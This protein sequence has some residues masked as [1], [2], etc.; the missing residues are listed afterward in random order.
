MKQEATKKRF[1]LFWVLYGLFVIAMIIFW[2]RAVSYV[3]Q[4]LIRYE[5]SQ[6][7]HS[8]DGV[9][10]EL[11]KQ[12]LESYVTI[13]GEMSRFETQE[14]FSR[15]AQKIVA[16]KILDYRTSRGVQDPS[17]PKYDLLADGEVVGSVTLK[18]TS[19]ETLFLNLLKISEWSL[20]KVEMKSVKGNH[21]V[22]I[23]ALDNCQVKING[24]LVDDRERLEGSETSDEFAYA[25]EYVEVPSVVKYRVEGLLEAPK[26]EIMNKDGEVMNA[27]TSVK[28]D[29]TKV[30]FTEFEETEMPKDLKA[31]VLEQTERY[32][33]FFSVDLPGCKGSV[34]P[35]RD[36]FP[37]DSYYLELAD[38]YRRE[39]MWMYSD[40]NAPVFKNEKVDHYVRYNE[41]FFSCEVFFDKEMVLKKTGKKKVDTTN[42]RMYYGL[43][44]GEWKIL[45]MVTLLST[46]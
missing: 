2:I 12:G 35:I 15:E 34:S 5:D 19:S 8:M 9:I 42:F 27:E 11:L 45:D 39:D 29:L 28:N 17:A 14:A 26:V 44:D 24:V 4:C 21:A 13:D 18:E 10:S 22:E 33:N 37:K 30:S 40:H 31:M 6:P 1:P 25:K 7:V 16:G 3:K 36:M 38:T 32:T 46:E 23:T 41:E 43:L 20:D